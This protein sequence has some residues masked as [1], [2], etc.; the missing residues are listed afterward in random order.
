MNWNAT[1]RLHYV[2]AG[3]LNCRF[4]VFCTPQGAVCSSFA[5]C[6]SLRTKPIVHA[7]L[8]LTCATS[9]FPHF[10]HSCNSWWLCIRFNEHKFVASSEDVD[11]TILISCGFKTYWYYVMIWRIIIHNDCDWLHVNCTGVWWQF[12][13]RYSF[14]CALDKSGSSVHKSEI[15]VGNN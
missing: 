3:V 11:N 5:E 15:K 4:I 10:M 2:H 6:I 7:N 1:R 13:C 9:P 12:I 8:S 14:G